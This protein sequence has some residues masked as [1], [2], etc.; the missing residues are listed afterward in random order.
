MVMAP[1]NQVRPCQY[2]LSATRSPVFHGVPL[3]RVAA[4]V[5]RIDQPTGACPDGVL[6]A[7]TFAATP[8]HVPLPHRAERVPP[9]LAQ[10]D[11]PATSD[12]KNPC[13]GMARHRRTARGEPRI[14]ELVGFVAT[15]CSSYCGLQSPARTWSRSPFSNPGVSA[16]LGQVFVHVRAVAPW[17]GPRYCQTSE[18]GCKVS[19]GELK[20]MAPD[21]PMQCLPERAFATFLFASNFDKTN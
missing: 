8:T 20:N 7:T 18:F 2:S 14:A 19:L 12:R 6:S 11:E 17:C 4:R 21:A 10:V 13:V 9:T 5:D 3:S 16:F 15:G 1:T